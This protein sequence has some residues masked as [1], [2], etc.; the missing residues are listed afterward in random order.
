MEIT[1]SYINS[2]APNIAAIKA[3][4]DLSKKAKFSNSFQSLDLSCIFSD[5]L[6]SSGTY[7]TSVDFIDALNPIFRCNCPS[8]Q[9]PCKHGLGLLYLFEEVKRFPVKEI[10]LEIIE[11]R[12][13][14]ENKNNKIIEVKNNFT[15]KDNL[16]KINLKKDT[17][18]EN[19]KIQKQIEGVELA[20]KILFSILSKGLKSIDAQS[21]RLISQQAQ[22]LGD[23]YINGIQNKF[24]NFLLLFNINNF[25]E[26]FE[27]IIISMLELNQL[28]K[29]A[30]KYLNT[31]I[32]NE[33]PL[34]DIN[35]DIEEQIGHIW[36]L[37][38]LKQY[39]LVKDKSKLLQL[40]FLTYSDY[41]K[42]E[43]V[44]EG[45]WIDVENGEIFKTKVYR[46]FRAINYVKSDDTVFELVQVSDL[47]IYPG[48]G[49]RR[50]RWLKAD[51]Y[52]PINNF[53][54]IT[55]FANNNFEEFLNKFKDDI[56][57][58]INE[59]KRVG[60]FNNI[61][62]FQDL[63]NNRYLKDTKGLILRL[64]DFSWYGTTT[65]DYLRF[66]SDKEMEG[67]IVCLLISYNHSMN[68][69]MAKPLSI[70]Y[71]NKILRLQ[72]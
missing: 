24:Q 51:K 59:N 16:K 43:F 34:R 7:F 36:K 20:E 68:I 50:I 37:E 26:D 41:S 55:K 27:E 31:K 71:P 21:R 58:P 3:A 65:T 35:S 28:V 25:T 19:K 13:K 9:F 4:K 2:L 49:N 17:V 72:F 32:L 47:A 22:R 48:K 39:S 63:N 66:I 57:N 61:K 45:I 42:S 10:P 56:K 46:P 23:Y 5:C 67:L 15:K 30:K 11:K 6:G 60:I 54:F 33:N 64:E 12:K 29:Q 53:D 52:D 38:E 70:V 40:N 69:F 1:A 62:L 8:R 14:I 18:K 44:D